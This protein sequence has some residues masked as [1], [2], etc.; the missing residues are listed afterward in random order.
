ML[1][2]LVYKL[3]RFEKCKMET[4]TELNADDDDAVN[5]SMQYSQEHSNR[6]MQLIIMR[7]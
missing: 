1:V 4:R 2:Y 7:C 5:D 3:L 6:Q